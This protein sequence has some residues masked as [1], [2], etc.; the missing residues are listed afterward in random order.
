MDAVYI[1]G[2]WAVNEQ[3]RYSLRSL[4][5]N[6]PYV[7]KVWI[8]GSCP[9]WVSDE[10]GKILLEPA[11]DKFDNQ[12]QSLRAACADDRISEDF[13]LMN[14][15]MF[16]LVE[17]PEL[18]VWHLGPLNLLI[19]RVRER[20]ETPENN[21]WVRGMVAMLDQMRDWGYRNPKAYEAHVPLPF[22]RKRLAHLIDTTTRSPFLAGCVYGATQ[23]PT[24]ALGDNVKIGELGSHELLTAMVSGIPFLSTE[25][26]AFEFGNV[27]LFL[28][29][30][31]PDP[32]IYEEAS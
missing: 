18:P 16:A 30:I 10:V 23:G 27:G 12:R 26:D 8:V 24:G 25:D 29:T 5:K 22:N 1:V 3:L 2:P 11:E 9:A 17:L 20:G 14:D 28:R 32:C 13:I 19:K 15:D 21:Q 7:D 6:M 31:F 4:A